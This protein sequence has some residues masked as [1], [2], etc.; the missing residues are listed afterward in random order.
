MLP[1]ECVVRG[2]LAGSGWKDYAA[3]GAVCGHTLPGG[4]R[5]VGR[6]ARADL[7]AGD[8][9][10]RPAT[11]R[12]STASRPPRWSAPT[13][14]AE[15]E[16]VSIALYRFAAE[17]ARERGILIADT[18][19]EFGLDARRAARARRRGA[20]ARTRRASGPPTSTRPAARSRR[21]T[22]SSSATTAR[23]SAG[24]RRHPGRSFPTD[25]V[26]GHAGTLRR[27]VRAADGHRVRRLPR[28]P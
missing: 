15:V 3:T 11:T 9:G 23:R 1:I 21:S 17:H 27:G 16:R 7:H 26:A 2:Y 25:V 10:A 4:L 14:F 20:D 19:F 18:K 8:E 12:T 28:R 5:R 6:A 24:T 13:C 22:S